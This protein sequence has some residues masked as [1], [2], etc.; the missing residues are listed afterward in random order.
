MHIIEI[1]LLEEEGGGSR[2]LHI[3][4]FFD[5]GLILCLSQHADS[6]VDCLQF[7]SQRTSGGGNLHMLQSAVLALFYTGA[8][9]VQDEQ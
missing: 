8:S 4:A 9:Y 6:A 1:E 5:V 3:F 2:T 7:L